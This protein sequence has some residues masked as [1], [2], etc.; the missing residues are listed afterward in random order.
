[1]N[2]SKSVT[3]YEHCCEIGR[4]G[5]LS[6]SDKKREAA[7]RNMAKARAAR[8]VNFKKKPQWREEDQW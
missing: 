2:K 4:Y 8:K 5:G 3:V 7:K 6:K 1:M